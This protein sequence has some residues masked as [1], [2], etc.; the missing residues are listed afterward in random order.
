LLEK[1][2]L[3]EKQLERLNSKLASSAGDEL[4]SQRDVAGVKIGGQ[5]NDVDANSTDMRPAEKQASIV[6]SVLAVVDGDKSI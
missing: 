4:G 3:L 5:L 2:K 1:T 6:L